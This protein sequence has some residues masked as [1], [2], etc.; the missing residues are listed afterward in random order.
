MSLAAVDKFKSRDAVIGIVGLGYVGLP[1]MLRYNAI[2]YCVLGID[3]DPVKVEK[4]NQGKATLSIFHA[5][6]SPGRAKAGFR[7][8]PIS[9]GLLSAMH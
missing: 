6:R 7:Q 9:V 3:I 5:N 8:L 4:L 1:L 2:G